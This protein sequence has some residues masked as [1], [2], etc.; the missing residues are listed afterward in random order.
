MHVLVTEDTLLGG[1]LEASD[2]AVLDLVKVLNSLC[3][4]NQY[5]GAV[6]V[7]AEAPDLPCFCD[8]V[9][10]LVGEISSSDLEV[11]PGVNIS[12]V[13]ILGKTIRHRHG[14]HEQPVVL[15]GRLAETHDAR[16]LAYSLSTL[17][18]GLAGLR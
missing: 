10:V 16:L 3:T 11:I 12:L 4:V 1:P 18:L 5:V 2:H 13:N 7:R 14:L 6:G 8:V 17:L 9:L 15:V